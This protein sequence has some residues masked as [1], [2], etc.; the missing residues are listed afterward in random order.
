[1]RKSSHNFIHVT[2]QLN[3]VTEIIER[4][5]YPTDNGI[6]RPPLCKIEAQ[7][8]VVTTLQDCWH[9]IPEARPD[10]RLIRSGLKPMQQGM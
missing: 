8:Y 7:Q 3:N 4:V 1:M 2:N 6:F 5:K 9:E 10:I